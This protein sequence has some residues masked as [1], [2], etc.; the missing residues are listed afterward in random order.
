MRILLLN[1]PAE[2]TARE[3]VDPANPADHG[4]L[5]TSDFG[6]FPPLGLLYIY[7]ALKQATAAHEL[8][9]LDCIAEKIGHDALGQRVA[10]MNPELIGITSF[11]VAMYDVCLAA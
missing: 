9:F 1:P 7:S 2:H 11:T 10:A 3:Y 4:L 6:L 5:E 8:L